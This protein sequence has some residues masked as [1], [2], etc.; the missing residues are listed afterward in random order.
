MVLSVPL[1]GLDRVAA[2]AVG[3]NWTCAVAVVVVAEGDDVLPMFSA[4][5]ASREVI[6]ARASSR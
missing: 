3:L 2:S 5:D 4:C 6:P 1:A